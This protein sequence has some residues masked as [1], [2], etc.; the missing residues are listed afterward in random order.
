MD[1][2][3]VT[4]K[5]GKNYFTFNNKFDQDHVF[6]MSSTDTWSGLSRG[7]AHQFDRDLG[8]FYCDPSLRSKVA[9]DTLTVRDQILKTTIATF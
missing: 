3:V 1:P 8:I 5:T 4:L 2:N 7:P 6:R 9:F